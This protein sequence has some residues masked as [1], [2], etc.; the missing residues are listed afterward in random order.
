MQVQNDCLQSKTCIHFNRMTTRAQGRNP[1]TVTPTATV[2]QLPACSNNSNVL[3]TD[4]VASQT[5]A[6]N[7]AVA[8][9]STQASVNTEL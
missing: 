5:N 4:V 3:T 2:S 6:N 9:N 1:S 8:S 7:A